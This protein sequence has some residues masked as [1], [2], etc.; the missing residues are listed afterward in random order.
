V[1]ARAFLGGAATSFLAPPPTSQ[2]HLATRRP[3]P[4]PHS[5]AQNFCKACID[6]WLRS[7]ET[8]PLC[9]APCTR[10]LKLAV[11]TVLAGI[12]ADNKGPRLRA[13]ADERSARFYAAL[14]A[15]DPKTALK[16]LTAG[17]DLERFVGE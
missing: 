14:E 16:E 7:K 8:C 3:P 9:K 2:P 1:R 11:N 10:A 17:I 15:D 5:H 13:R 6:E 12:I 4:P